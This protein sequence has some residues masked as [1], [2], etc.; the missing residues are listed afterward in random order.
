MARPKL[1]G[2]FKLNMRIPPSVQHRLAELA[3]RDETTVSECARRLL[4]QAI[5][6]DQRTK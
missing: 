1:Y 6:H 3:V 5:N 2:G 4:I